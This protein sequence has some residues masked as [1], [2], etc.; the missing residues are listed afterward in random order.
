MPV[1]APELEF[2]LTK[3]N[4]DPD[5]P[6]EPPIGPLGPS[7]RR[8]SGLQPRRRRRVRQDRRR[9]LRVRRAPVPE[10]R[11]DHPGRRRR[12]ARD[13][14]PARRSRPSRRSGF[15]V[16]AHDPRGRVHARLLCD[17]HGQAAREPAGQRHAH[18]SEH[19]R[20]QD[21][22]EHLHQTRTASRASCSSSFLAGQQLYLPSATCLFA[23]YV[24]SYRRLVPGGAAPINVEWGHDNRSAGLRIP[25]IARGRAPCRE[26]PRRSRFQSL[27]RDRRQ[28]C[29]R[30]SRHEERARAASSP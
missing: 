27:S 25:D 10:D 17:V 30:L 26:P 11:H 14:S 24:N 13:Q 19:H 3:T 21:R 1:V 23:P 12:A 7:R 29:L 22:Q 20:R 8:P 15:P 6:L 18:P 9:H 28:P 4:P 16:Q 2:Y 5:Y